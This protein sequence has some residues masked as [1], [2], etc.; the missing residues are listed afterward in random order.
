ML[1]AFQTWAADGGSVPVAQTPKLAPKL[2][3]INGDY[4][5][6]M[7]DG[8]VAGFFQMIGKVVRTSLGMRQIENTCD[9]GQALTECELELDIAAKGFSLRWVKHPDANKLNAVVQTYTITPNGPDNK[10][11]LEDS[12]Q[13]MLWYLT[14]RDPAYAKS[15][16]PDRFKCKNFSWAQDIPVKNGRLTLESWSGE[17]M[18]ETPDTKMNENQSVSTA[19]DVTLKSIDKSTLEIESVGSAKNF[20]NSFPPYFATQVANITFIDK[21]NR[22]CQVS[23]ESS[24]DA[25][26]QMA[27]DPVLQ[28]LDPATQRPMKDAS[29]IQQT[30]FIFYIQNLLTNS[31]AKGVE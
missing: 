19:F 9:F 4:F 7:Q 31:E 30:S 12:G 27:R 20:V 26:L 8:R 17:A 5:I 14:F 11:A 1:G 10:Q 2:V 16:K 6:D 21:K 29:A 22:Q 15:F 13:F 25:I 3:K 24:L 23:F 18:F 28:Q